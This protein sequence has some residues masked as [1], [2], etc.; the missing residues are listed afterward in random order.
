MESHQDRKRR[1]V[2]LFH[3]YI[4]NPVNRILPTQVVLETTGRKSGLPRRV[5]IGGQLV[6]DQFWLVSDHGEASDYVRNIKHNNRVRLR[7]HGRWRSGVAHLIHTDDAHARLQTLP[8]LNSA[9]VRALGT[10]LLTV[11]IDLTK[12]PPPP[13]IA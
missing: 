8:R 13:P 7:I 12:Q 1:R 11:R 2:S 9:M 5:P 10:N 4:A 6:D 3:K